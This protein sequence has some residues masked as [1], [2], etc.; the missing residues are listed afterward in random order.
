MGIRRRCTEC[1]RSFTPSPRA[2]SSQCVCSPECR[3]ARNR[4][5]ARAR[6]SRDIEAYREDEKHRQQQSRAERARTVS[7]P[8]DA[9]ECHAPPST[10]KALDSKQKIDWIVARVMAASRATFVRE[11]TRITAASREIVVKPRPS[12]RATFRRQ[13]R[14]LA[15][16]SGSIPGSCH[17]P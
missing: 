16:E 13:A 3:A 5:L 6:R 17:A 7:P 11:L 9:R 10:H 15:K 14:E 2:A 1:R 4:K 8:P 12:S